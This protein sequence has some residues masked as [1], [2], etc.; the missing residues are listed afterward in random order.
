MLER[1]LADP[2]G[3]WILG[4]HP[5]AASEFSLST[6]AATAITTVRADRIFRAGPIPHAPGDECF[7]IIDYKTAAHGTAG[8]EAFLASQRDHYAA[9]LETYARVLGPVVGS[10]QVRVGLYFAALPRL[11]WWEPAITD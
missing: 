4:P 10:S 3:L 2:E 11:L 8:L 6:T 7:W 9:Q 5:D 1:V